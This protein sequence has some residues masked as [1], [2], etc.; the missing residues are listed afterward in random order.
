MLLEIQEM[1]KGE[2]FIGV[3]IH[4][5]HLEN[6]DEMRQ[7]FDAGPKKTLGLRGQQKVRCR[8]VSNDKGGFTVMVHLTVDRIKRFHLILKGRANRVLEGLP[9]LSL[10]AYDVQE[11]SWV[12]SVRM[13]N[14]VRKEY[15]NCTGRI[16]LFDNFAPHFDAAAIKIM[17]ARLGIE[18]CC[19]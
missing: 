11:S 5:P 1:Y 12:D 3:D 14:F 17:G 9:K 18:C 6:M 13:Q 19:E 16:A 10:V 15:T 4:N 2:R 7:V 8:A